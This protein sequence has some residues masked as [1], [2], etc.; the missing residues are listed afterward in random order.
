M[1]TVEEGAVAGVV[2]AEPAGGRN[3]HGQLSP[4]WAQQVL[5]RRGVCRSGSTSLG[6]GHRPNLCSPGAEIRVP[7]GLS[8][9]RRQPS[10][11]P[12]STV[13]TTESPDEDGQRRW[14]QTNQLPG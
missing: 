9:A 4:R 3:D 14:F 1:N 12:W 2:G 11:W 8:N 10:F 13:S 6:L 5:A 7:P